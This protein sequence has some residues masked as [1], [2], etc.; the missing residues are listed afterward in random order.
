MERAFQHSCK[1]R[2]HG[3]A[4][5]ESETGDAPRRNPHAIPAFRGATEVDS[6]MNERGRA[7]ADV[8]IH[9]NA[10]STSA[11]RHQDASSAIH[12]DDVTAPSPISFAGIDHVQIAAPPRCEAE[13]R[14]FFGELLGLPELPKPPALAIR[15]GLWFQCGAQQLHIGIEKDFRPAK[16]AHPALRLADEASL[17]RLKARLK[18]A[19]VA[20]RDDNEREDTARFFAEDPWGNRMEFVAAVDPSTA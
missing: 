9:P 19:G 7:A 10:T 15:G 8:M 11:A 20:T 6:P 4:A 16:K 14:R 17:D 3:R 1:D 13:A 5:P 12:C 2:R 18:A